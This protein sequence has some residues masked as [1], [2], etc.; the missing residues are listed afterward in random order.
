MNRSPN[1]L[2]PIPFNKSN[3][4]LALNILDFYPTH[5]SNCSTH[6]QSTYST[7]PMNNYWTHTLPQQLETTQ[8]GSMEGRNKG[9]M[10]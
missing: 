3:M 6:R 5:S 1:P 7:P 2:V 10:T 4:S 9:E 8:C